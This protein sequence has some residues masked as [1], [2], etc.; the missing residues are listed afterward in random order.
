ML[1]TKVPWSPEWSRKG[2]EDAGD[3][4]FHWSLVGR[5]A[6]LLSAAIV[7]TALYWLL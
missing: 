2:A 3:E 5:L 6:M 4:G 1:S 7:L